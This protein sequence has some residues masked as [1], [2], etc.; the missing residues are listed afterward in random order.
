MEPAQF[1]FGGGI[2][3][4]GGATDMIAETG[5]FNEKPSSVKQ[6]ACAEDYNQKYRANMEDTNYTL[7]KFAGD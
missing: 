4:P 7:D 2:F 3:G 6:F 1:S 5:S